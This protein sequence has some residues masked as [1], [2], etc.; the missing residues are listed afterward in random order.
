MQR[1][2]LDCCTHRQ[3]DSCG[4][5]HPSIVAAPITRR[6]TARPS[7]TGSSRSVVVSKILAILLRVLPIIL[8]TLLRVLP[9]ILATLLPAVGTLL[10]GVR[11]LSSALL[12]RIR[13]VLYGLLALSLVLTGTA[14]PVLL[15]TA[16]ILLVTAPTLLA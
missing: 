14:L 11:A 7:T 15:I 3:P 5:R 13:L 16:S 12:A 4:G 6:T 8:T 10:V 9:V 2:A 1:K